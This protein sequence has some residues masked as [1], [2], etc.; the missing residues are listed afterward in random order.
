VYAVSTRTGFTR[1]GLPDLRIVTG[2]YG[3]AQMILLSYILFIAVFLSYLFDKT[4]G[5]AV[6]MALLERRIGEH[7]RAGTPGR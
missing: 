2:D 5:Y 7:P 1:Y 4:R 3:S 6:G